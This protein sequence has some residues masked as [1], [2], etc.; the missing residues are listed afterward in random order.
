M[1]KFYFLLLSFLALSLCA[2][3]E[4][5]SID[6]ES[7]TTA[8]TDWTFENMTSQQTGSI[9]AHG[10]TNYGTTGGKETASITTKSAI[11]APQS[12]TFYVSKQSKNTTAS[13]WKLQVSSDNSTWTDVKTQSATSMTKGVWV[14]VTQDLS[15][16][17]NVYVR[18]YYTG[19]TAVRNI[20]DVELIA[21]AAI[22]VEKPEITETSTGNYGTA[23]LTNSTAKAKIACATE[24]AAI[25]YAITNGT[26]PANEEWKVY[27]AEVSFTSEAAGTKTLWAK[28]VKGTDESIE[29]KKEFKFEASIANTQET[30]Y[31]TKQAIE[32]ID[33]TSTEQ[34]AA[35]KV[36][37]KGEISKIDNYNSTYKSITYW[38]DKNTFEVYSGKGLDNADFAA[39]T[40]IEPFAS[41]IVF[42][43]IK[44]YNSTYEFDKNNYLVKYTAP[45]V[46]L[47]SLAISGTPSNT[48][49]AEGATFDPA[50]LTVTGTYSNASTADV[51][52]SV[53]WTFEPETLALGTTQVVATATYEGQTASTTV[54]VTVLKTIKYELVVDE[55][56]IV[57]GAKYIIADSKGAAVMGTTLDTK[58]G[59]YNAIE[60]GFNISGNMLSISETAEFASIEF[61]TVPEPFGDKTWFVKYNNGDDT[62]TYLK[63]NA[64]KFTTST[65]G[66]DAASISIEAD[67]TVK[68]IFAS[69]SDGYYLK[70][71]EGSPRFKPYTSSSNIN[72]IKLY[73]VYEESEPTAT[74]T[75]L[76]EVLVGDAG[77]KYKISC[78][79][80]VNYKD[81]N[82]VY[83]STIGGGFTK[84][85]APT[86][87]QKEEWWSD[88]EDDFNQNDWVAIEG[89]DVELGT[90]IAGGSTVVLCKNAAF[91]VVKFVS[92]VTL[93]PTIVGA[94][95]ANTFRVANFDSN[96]ELVKKLWLVEPQPAEHCFVKGYVASLGDV[97][98]E[99]GVGLASIKSGEKDVV[100]MDV[101][102]N[103]ADFS[104]TTTGWYLF[105]G[106]VVNGTSGLELNAVKMNEGTATGVEGVE[107]SSVKVYGAEG[108]I[109]VESEEVAP[110]AVYSANGAI[111]SSVEA[112]SA[113]IAVAPGF[114]IVKAGNSVSKVTVK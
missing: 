1:K 88:K 102:Y 111:V 51:T 71:N 103:T 104:I 27:S 80:R 13:S 108:V 66:E 100:T 87:A 96:N 46:T 36:Y 59:Y 105:E 92:E 95:D 25:K 19:S 15:S 68:M 52:S 58:N 64:D 37:V 109:N 7:A 38:L 12:I 33:A 74:S 45:V 69:N 30:A 4:V 67:N 50:G 16:Y 54:D 49:Y 42:G 84:K 5:L 34:L 26:K 62:Y 40:D 53:V 94:I 112:S 11:E 48:T 35:V 31:T 24:G 2:N 17:S 90:E 99:A 18:I 114:Y 89:L 98:E 106:V 97:L 57:A 85:V 93:S 22:V 63:G 28:A 107:T 86:E 76:D 110:I 65:T 6:F 81:D 10:G 60:S 77:K 75:G 3:A 72:F 29:V 113:S 43:N 39:E 9:T 78:P 32:L 61:E 20:D 70:Y 101:N 91:P 79:L 47:Q 44:K 8:Y 21:G 14:E 73:R 23:Y 41:V 83:A 82:Y 55:S 56:Q